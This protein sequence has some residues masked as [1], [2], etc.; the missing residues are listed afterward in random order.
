MYKNNPICR[1]CNQRGDYVNRM[2]SSSNDIASYGQGQLPTHRIL[3]IS[4]NSVTLLP[5]GDANYQPS[6][7]KLTKS[8]RDFNNQSLFFPVD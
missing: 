5:Q 1:D 7:K 3:F 4:G 8:S 6:N 2:E